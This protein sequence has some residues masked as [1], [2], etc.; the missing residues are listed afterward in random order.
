LEIGLPIEFLYGWGYSLHRRGGRLVFRCSSGFRDVGFEECIELDGEGSIGVDALREACRRGVRVAVKSRHGRAILD[1]KPLVVKQVERFLCDSDRLL[2][3]KLVAE[4][5]ASNKLYLM[6]LLG[7][8]GSQEYS[9]IEELASRFTEA[10]TVWGVMAVEAEVTRLYYE[11]LR[12]VIPGDYGFTARS[13]R[14]P[15]DPVSASMSFLNMMLYSLCARAL[16]YHGLDER[17][18]F[19]HEPRGD[20]ASLALDLAEEFRQPLVDSVVIPAFT[21]RS[22]RKS[23]FKYSVNGVY[24]NDWGR[25]K[26]MKLYRHKLNLRTPLGSFE[27][28]VYRQAE[29]LA[30]WVSGELEVYRPFKASLL[31][32]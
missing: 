3:A 29:Q 13:R 17:L 19:L 30:K 4:A 1:S 23:D 2:I 14:P 10:S 32:T 31:A 20:R 22:M 26:L 21:S 7:L 12:R 11:S 25:G 8:Q 9:A 5:S 24:L 16:R 6:G 15:R 27:Q 18:G 28:L